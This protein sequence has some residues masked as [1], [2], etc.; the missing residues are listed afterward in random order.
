MNIQIKI[1]LTLVIGFILLLIPLMLSYNNIND[2]NKMLKHLSRDQIDFNFYTNKLNYDIKKN[3]TDVLQMVLLKQDRDDELNKK[4]L[5][6]INKS[7]KKL[8]KLTLKNSDL[9]AQFKQTLLTIKKR[10]ISYTIVQDSLCNAIESEDKFDIADAIIGFNNIAIKFSEDTELLMDY[11]NTELYQNVFLIEENNNNSRSTLLFSFLIAMFLISYSI[12]EFT[13]LNSSIKVQLKRKQ[14]AEEALKKAQEQLLKYNDDLEAE[15]TKK[16][17]ELHDKIYTSFLSGLPNRNKLMEDIK[18]QNFTK[19]AILNID[20]F[21]SFNDVYGEEVGNIALGQTAEF[22]EESLQNE[23]L[24]LYH[25][26]G[27]EFCI[28]SKSLSFNY[29]DIFIETIEN[30]LNSYKA[31]HFFYEDKSFQFMMSAGVSFSGNKK[32]LAYADMALKDAKKRNIQISLFNEDKELEKIHQD[33]IECH[34]KLIGAIKRH[35]ILSYFQPIVPIQNSNRPVKYES[36][37]RMRDESGKIIPPFNFLNVA[38]A[39]RI[40][41]KITRSVIINTLDTIAKYKI[42]CSINLSLADINNGTTMKY[43]FEL[44]NNYEHNDLITIELLE[45]EDFEDY[46]RVYEFCMKARSYGVKIALDDFGAGY[47]NFSHILNLPVEYIKI[48][49]SLISDIDR[50]HNSKIMVETIVELAKKLNVLTIAEFVS[51]K[52]ILKIVTSLGVDYAQGFYIGKPDEI[53]KHLK[54]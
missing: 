50:N 28:V 31:T 21:Q 19:M 39:N 43:F 4:Q 36:L 1:Y 5:K 54:S 18:I 13:K 12:Y 53:Q 46:D 40:Y 38:K 52:E 37:V 17:K 3:Q 7:I 27:D 49:A 10:L 24:T 25:I 41:Y 34:K 2:N 47:S 6:S 16:T 42:P 14:E 44:L 20:K 45:T 9:N 48:D 33:D 32:M 29:T 51:S 11:S 26:G 23:E 8:D 15:I 30:V 22:L 35:D